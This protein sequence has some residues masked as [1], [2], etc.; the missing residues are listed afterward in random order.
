MISLDYF[1]SV[2]LVSWLP[3]VV[4]FGVPGPFDEVLELSSPAM[5]SVASYLFHLI[6]CFSVNKVRWGT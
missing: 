4:T 1:W 6:F 2:Y 5:T 3:R